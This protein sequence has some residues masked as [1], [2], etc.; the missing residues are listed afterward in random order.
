[1]PL[2]KER[3]NGDLYENKLE[4]ADNR[5]GNSTCNGGIVCM[6]GKGW[7]EKLCGKRKTATS[8]AT[9]VALPYCMDDSLPSYGNCL[10]SGG[11]EEY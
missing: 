1:M 3:R 2:I 7:Y 8:F 11:A 5:C 9:N 4:K 10:I 6:A